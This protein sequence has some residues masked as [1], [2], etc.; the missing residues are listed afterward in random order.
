M[1]NEFIL[2]DLNNKK[3]NEFFK[4]WE[5][6]KEELLDK[7]AKKFNTHNERYNLKIEEFGVYIRDIIVEANNLNKSTEKTDWKIYIGSECAGEWR[8]LKNDSKEY[9]EIFSEL[10]KR[11]KKKFLGKNIK[12]EVY[13][14][15]NIGIIFKISEEELKSLSNDKLN[16]L[17]EENIIYKISCVKNITQQKIK[18]KQFLEKTI[19]LNNLNEE[20]FEN[21]FKEID[22]SNKITFNLNDDWEIYNG[23]KLIISNK[24]FKQLIKKG[25]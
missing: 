21:I 14:N 25:A 5:I 11:I 1:N 9:E 13:F 2:F 23:N 4:N 22:D 15:K 12:A 3:V 18:A 24:E 6:E 10:K 20:F 8:K 17:S 7:I 16:V 19:N